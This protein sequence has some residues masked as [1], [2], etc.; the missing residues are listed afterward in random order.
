MTDKNCANCRRSKSIECFMSAS[1]RELNT[2]DSCRTT[3]KTWRDK[4]KE[5][6]QDYRDKIKEKT[7]TYYDTNSAQIIEQQRKYKELNALKVKERRRAYYLKN[8][9]EIKKKQNEKR[10]QKNDQISIS[11]NI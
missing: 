2:C 1:K 7:K 8:A 9:E 3:A 10:K 6:L 4:N 11:N 5:H